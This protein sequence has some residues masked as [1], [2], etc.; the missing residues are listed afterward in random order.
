MDLEKIIKGQNTGNNEEPSVL[1][2][3]NPE[4]VESMF[5][6]F[7][8][9]FLLKPKFL[10]DDSF[11]YNKYIK[12]IEVLVDSLPAYVSGLEKEY[13]DLINKLQEENNIKRPDLIKRGDKQV[14]EEA[15]FNS[16]SQSEER[17]IQKTKKDVIT[18]KENI[19]SKSE[20]SSSNCNNLLLNTLRK[21]GEGKKGLEL[22][23]CSLKPENKESE[24]DSEDI[25]DTVL[26]IFY[27]EED[28]FIT[29]LKR[30]FIIDC[31]KQLYQKNSYS[32]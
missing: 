20:V 13:F 15:S 14:Q 6:I 32:W 3:G 4:D 18:V 2:Q 27:N 29:V 7:K 24:I 16:V 28:E 12:E 10:S 25:M 26:D 5:E 19:E 30:L 11:V 22:E 1:N 9:P 8:I 17:E 31:V 23:V 21:E